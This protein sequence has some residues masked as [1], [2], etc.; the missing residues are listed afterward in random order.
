MQNVQHR[1]LCLNN[2]SSGRGSLRKVVKSSEGGGLEE[3]VGTLGIALRFV[4]L[5]SPVAYSFLPPEYGYN[6]PGTLPLLSLW[7][8]TP[9]MDCIPTNCK[10]K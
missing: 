9:M 4:S 3:E 2:G 1:P 5:A 10:P 7:F 6:V 8:L